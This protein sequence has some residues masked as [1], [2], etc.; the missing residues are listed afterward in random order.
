MDTGS[1]NKQDGRIGQEKKGRII[2]TT[3]QHNDEGEKERWTTCRVPTTA[4]HDE[5]SPNGEHESRYIGL[6]GEQSRMDERIE[7]TRENV[8]LL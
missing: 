1:G 4:R 6:E 7:T 5:K 8:S 2:T 3:I